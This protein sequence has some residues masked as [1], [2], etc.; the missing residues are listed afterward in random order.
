MSGRFAYLSH[1]DTEWGDGWF[2]LWEFSFFVIVITVLLNIIFG[3][4][5][6]TLG[7]L[8]AIKTDTEDDMNNKCFVCSIDRYTMD[9]YQVSTGGFNFHVQNDHILEKVTG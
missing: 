5:I 4:I 2:L 8:R 1:Q 9:R 6:D 7:E 3:I